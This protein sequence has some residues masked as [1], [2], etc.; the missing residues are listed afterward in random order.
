MDRRSTLWREKEDG[1]VLEEDPEGGGI[2]LHEDRY[3]DEGPESVERDG[4]GEDG[5][6]RGVGER[7][8]SWG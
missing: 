5:M 8:G 7:K 1:P 2:R 3:V 6:D 4:E